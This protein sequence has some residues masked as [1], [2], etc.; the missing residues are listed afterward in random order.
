MR[1]RMQ[2]PARQRGAIAIIFALL[3]VTLAISV[4]ASLSYDMALDARRTATLLW[5]EQAREVAYGAESWVGDVLS[6]DAIDTETD[7]FGEL[8]AIELPPLPVEGPGISGVITGQLE[9]MQGRFNINNLIDASGNMDPIALAQLQ[10]LL[11]SVGIDP[12]IA[13]VI[14]DWIDPD[15]QPEFPQGAEDDVYTSRLPPLRAANRP[16]ST[17]SELAVVEGLTPEQV[18]QLRPHL[19]ALPERTRINVN[20]ATPI[21]LQSLDDTLDAT[22]VEFLVEDRQETGFDDVETTFA[23]LVSPDVVTQLTDSSRYFRLR[24]IVRIGTVRFTMYSL[25]HRAPDGRITVL[26]RSFGT[27]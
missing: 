3:I 16:L 13:P 1:R 14:A 7:H 8:W 11:E 27:E 17:A 6:Q 26:L 10:R 4:A 2:P 15:V 23:S 24:S 9:D 20:T 19:V 12:A 5:Q 18:E 22:A 25:L 21:V